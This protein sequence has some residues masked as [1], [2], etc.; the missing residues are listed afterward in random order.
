MLCRTP[1]VD[2]VALTTNAL[3]LDRLALPLWQ[4]GLRRL[5]ISLD[6]LD[7]DSFA[8]ITGRNA[9]DQAWSGILAAEATGFAPLTTNTVVMRGINCEELP[10]L[11][12]LARQRGWHVRF[13]E[14]MPLDGKGQWRRQQMV[15]MSEILE[16]INAAWPLEPVDA[17]PTS[18]A[19]EFQFV[20]G[21]GRIGVIGSVTQSFCG[22]CDRIRL[23]ADGQLRTCLFS[24]AQLDLRGPLRDGA[25]DDQLVRLIQHAVADKPAGHK[26]DQAQFVRPTTSMFAIG[27]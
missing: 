25:S 8:R 3:L 19:R 15:P 6:T 24:D 14:F 21:P 1:G 10:A 13:I 2:E 16:R 20:D 22:S 17:P 27:G 7:P 23:T 11:A 4:A 9:F 18:P 26:M 12:D 5:N